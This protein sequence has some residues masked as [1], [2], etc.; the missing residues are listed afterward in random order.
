MDEYILKPPFQIVN[1]LNGVITSEDLVASQWISAQLISNSLI[2]LLDLG[3]I[4]KNLL[5]TLNN[6]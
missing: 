1:Q 5:K 4:I 6:D 3:I 2:S